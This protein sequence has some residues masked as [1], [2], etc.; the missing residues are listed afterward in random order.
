MKV[1][2][3]LKKY[4]LPNL[5]YL[6]ASDLLFSQEAIRQSSTDSTQHFAEV[7][8]LNNIG[9]FF[10]HRTLFHGNALLFFESYLAAQI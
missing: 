8:H 10:K 4:V 6:D 9:I 1:S 7:I 5:P 3:I 2:D